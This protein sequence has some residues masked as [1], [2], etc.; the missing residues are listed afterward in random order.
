MS[1]AW[2]VLL[3]GGGG[4]ALAYALMQAREQGRIEDKEFQQWRKEIRKM[5]LLIT[6]HTPRQYGGCANDKAAH[7]AVAKLRQLHTGLAVRILP[8]DSIGLKLLSSLNRLIADINAGKVGQESHAEVVSLFAALL[9]ERREVGQPSTGF[10][11][12]GILRWVYQL[13]EYL[14]EYD[15]ERKTN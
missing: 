10:S 4:F 3:A 15:R 9:A 7:M 6:N 11:F 8:D 2:A 1:D 13:P 5:A 12:S 14:T